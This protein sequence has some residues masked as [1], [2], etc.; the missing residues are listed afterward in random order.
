M[1][2]VKF[3]K[4]SKTQYENVSNKDEDTLYVTIENGDFSEE[5]LDSNAD[6][7]IGDKRISTEVTQETGDSTTAVM[8]QKAVSDYIKDISDQGYSFRGL[9]LP[10]TT[11]QNYEN[12]KVFYLAVKAG[13]YTQFG[14]SEVVNFSF[15]LY[16]KE[17][18]LI[19]DTTIPFGVLSQANIKEELEESEEAKTNVVSQNYV[20]HTSKKILKTFTWKT[21]DNSNN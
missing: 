2:R 20:T 3:N 18:W 12:R 9:C 13:I 11:P 10:T 21:I 8:S 19:G 1:G 6:L 16:D 5:N 15:L 14:N 7:F 17:E 4:L